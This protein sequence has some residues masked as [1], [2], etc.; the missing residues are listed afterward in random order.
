MKRQYSEWVKQRAKVQEERNYSY[1]YRGGQG[2][3]DVGMTVR[4]ILLWAFLIAM[5][6]SVFNDLQYAGCP[7]YDQG[8]NCGKCMRRFEYM[9]ERR[10]QGS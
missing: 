10:R 2:G 7:R 9:K 4:R 6:F 8:C 5:F 3:Q 1:S